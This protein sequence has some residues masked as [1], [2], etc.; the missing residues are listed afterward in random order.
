MRIS[1]NDWHAHS[2]TLHQEWEHV[3]R[4]LA[5]LEERQRAV[6][7]SQTGLDS[8][9]NRL[10]EEEQNRRTRLQELE[11]EK[12]RLEKELCRSLGPGRGST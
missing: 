5:V 6:S 8:D 4:T 10:V 3:S 9:L 11:V 12:T 1:L 7:N 2:A